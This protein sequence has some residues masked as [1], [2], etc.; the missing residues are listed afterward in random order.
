MRKISAALERLNS[1]L[2]LYANQQA[3]SAEAVALHRACLRGFVDNGAIP[4]RAQMLALAGGKEAVVN[5]LAKQALVVFDRRGEPTGAYPFTMEQRVHRVSL[6]GHTV[7]AM[8]ALDALSIHAMYGLPVEIRSRCAFS[9]EPVRIVQRDGRPG[10]D[11]A[12]GVYLGVNWNAASAGYSCAD[13]LCT[14]MV[15]LKD[16]NIARQWQCQDDNDRERFTLDEAMAFGEAF[17]TP[18]AG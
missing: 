2:P 9:G 3:M 8:C 1:I 18:L 7:Y 15:F 13:S 5:E 14:E 11:E 4:D 17:F 12:Q 10:N 16:K 6:N